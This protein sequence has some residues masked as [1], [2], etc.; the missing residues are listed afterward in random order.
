MRVVT[1]NIRRA[2]K[3]SPAWGLLGEL[4][5][6]L[7]FLQE[8]GSIPERIQG[9]FD[10]LSRAAV[11]KRGKPQRFSTAVLV[12][13]KIAKEISLSSDK[14]WVNREL[15][16]FEGNFVGCLVQP[17]NQ[18][19]LCAVSVYCP[20]WPVDRDRLNGIDVSSVRLKSQK[21]RVWATEIIWDALKNTVSSNEKWMVGGDYNSSETFD[22]QWQEK[23]AV[24]FGI[25]SSGNREILDRMHE[26]GF[27]E[28]LRKY[29]KDRIV[30][31]FKNRSNNEIAHQ[32]DHLF[33][34]NNLYARLNTCTTGDQ[35][36]IFGRA[37]SDHLPI[38]ADFNEKN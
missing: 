21:T 35:P 1:W 15:E 14:G 11:S 29:N 13:G 37:L 32:I 2:E 17:Q 5:P 23:N 10:V 12:K 19:T 25:R 3:G 31:T 28:C 33:V 22:K 38:I 34:T 30:P 7:V 27:T 20:A 4:H 16:F 6:D 24:K 26:I 18:E 36:T 9:S 8:V